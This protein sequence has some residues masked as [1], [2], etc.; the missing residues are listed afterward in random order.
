[1]RSGSTRQDNGQKTVLITSAGGLVGTYLIRHLSRAG[2]YQLIGTDMSD[3][4]SQKDK[5]SGFYLTP[6]ANTPGYVEEIRRIVAAEKVEVIIPVSSHDMEVYSKKEAM[7]K[8][9]PAK[10]LVMDYE[11]HNK[12]HDKV[13]C[14]QF[15]SSLGIQVPKRMEEGCGLEFPCVLKADKSTGSKGTV[16]LEEERDYFYWKQKIEDYTIYEYLPGREYTVDCL[17]DRAGSCIGYNPR[18]RVKLNGGG[19]VISC[20]IMEKRLETVIKK[21][22]FCK[23]IKGPVNFQYKLVD[24]EIVVF[25]FNTRLASGGL[26]VSVQAGFCIPEMLIDLALENEVVLWRPDEKNTGLTML[27]YYDEAYIRKQP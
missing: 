22:E 20:C 26:P 17:F 15:L 16:V 9:Y 12:L 10:L 7:E 18:E 11:T 23:K 25:D 5:L 24:G 13:K 27:R 6:A 4:V 3:M 8:L 14:G 1:M 2:K 21:L 19:A